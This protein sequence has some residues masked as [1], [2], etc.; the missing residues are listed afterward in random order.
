MEICC[1]RPLPRTT[2]AATGHLTGLSRL[3][4]YYAGMTRITD[5]SLEILSRLTA[6]ERVELREIAG[7]TDAGVKALAALPRLREVSI[8]GSPRVTRAGVAQFAEHVR[9]KYEP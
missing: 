9:V 5:R 8:G 7:I 3:R 1:D 2:D 6:L 4:P